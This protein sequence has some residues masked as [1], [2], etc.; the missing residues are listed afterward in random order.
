MQNDGDT[1]RESNHSNLA[2]PALRKL[3][4]PVRSHV[5]NNAK[6]K[7]FVAITKL[8]AAARLPLVLLSAVS[9]AK[10]HR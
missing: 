5:E 8:G 7:H 4:S 1:T 2:A 9:M 10:R 3:S 6:K